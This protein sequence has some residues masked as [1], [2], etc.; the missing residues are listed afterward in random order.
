MTVAWQRELSRWHFYT[1][2]VDIVYILPSL[3]GRPPMD[4]DNRWHW[5]T[6]FALLLLY[7]ILILMIFSIP[8]TQ[9]KSELRHLI[10]RLQAHA[11]AVCS[12][13]LEVQSLLPSCR[14]DNCPTCWQQGWHGA[15]LTPVLRIVLTVGEMRGRHEH[16][17][18]P[19]PLPRPHR[20]VSTCQLELELQTKVLE[21]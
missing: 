12:G 17:P 13:K 19:P 21:D 5:H 3:L 2:N 10:S 14:V 20:Q 6:F 8:K 4:S 7:K 1:V 16:R 18:L 9:D 11:M 15:E